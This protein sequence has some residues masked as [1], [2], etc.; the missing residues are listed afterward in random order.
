MLIASN[1]YKRN[2]FVKEEQEL[3]AQTLLLCT[4]A[5]NTWQTYGR[6]YIRDNF[7]KKEILHSIKTLRRENVDLTFAVQVNSDMF[8]TEKSPF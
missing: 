5:I 7:F 1:T 8:H 3:H 2:N 4:P 6:L